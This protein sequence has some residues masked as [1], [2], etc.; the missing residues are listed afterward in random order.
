MAITN[1][2]R[3]FFGLLLLLALIGRS[4]AEDDSIRAAP[5]WD[6]TPRSKESTRVVWKS[7]VGGWQAGALGMGDGKILVGSNDSRPGLGGGGI[8]TALDSSGRL[9]RIAIR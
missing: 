2:C 4:G 5:K 7:G 8:M 1:V 6:C 9:L 3:F